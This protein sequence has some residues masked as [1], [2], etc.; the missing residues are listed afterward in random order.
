[1]ATG[2]I[3]KYCRNMEDVEATP[4]TEGAR[5]AASWKRGSMIF[6][7]GSKLIINDITNGG[8][9][10]MILFPSFRHNKAG[11]AYLPQTFTKLS[12]L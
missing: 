10:C 4:Q 1:M 6:E 3:L 11:N 9:H 2:K 12:C 8:I 5:V 7:S